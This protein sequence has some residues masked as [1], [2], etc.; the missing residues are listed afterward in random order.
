MEPD[1]IDVLDENARTGKK[2][3]VVVPVGFICDHVE[4]LYDLDFESKE[5]AESLGLN[6]FRVPTVGT[7]P[8]FIHMLADSVSEF[9]AREKV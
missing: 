9:I 5:H 6:F 7:H 8:S 2:N 3:V 1:I 4:V